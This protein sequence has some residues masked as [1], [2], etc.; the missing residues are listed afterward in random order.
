MKTLAAQDRA[1]ARWRTLRISTLVYCLA[2]LLI[3]LATASLAFVGQIASREANDQATANELRL[4]D[5]A[6]RDRMLLLARDQLTVA[7][8]DRSVANI[9]LRFNPGF[10]RYEFVDS[11]WYE[12]SHNRIFLVDPRGSLLAE[13]R[14]HEVDF[15]RRILAPGGALQV[16]ATNAAAHYLANRIAI[17]DGFG[18][19]SVQGAR[20]D[21]VAEFAYAMV[22]GK[23]ALISAMPIVP[24]DGE[25]V[26]PDGPPVV[27]MS[28]KFIDDTLVEELNAQ[29][30]FPDMTFTAGAGGLPEGVVGRALVAANGMPIGL[31]RWTGDTPGQHIWSVVV[32]VILLLGGLIAAAAI[33]VA[34]KIGT[35]STALE[36]SERDNRHRARHDQLTGLANRLQFSACLDGAVAGL[37]RQ[38]FALIACDLDRFKAVNDTYGHAAGDAVIRTVAER[39]SATVGAAGVVGRIGGDE[40]V[41]L[42]HGFADRPRLMVLAQQILAGLRLP[43]TL[44]DG[45]AADIGI[46]LGIARAPGCAATGEGLMAAADRALY[47]AKARGRGLAVFAEDPD[48]NP[49]DH[50]PPRISDAA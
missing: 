46:S 39:L 15:S 9:A 25:V 35:L 3:A 5:N 14:E 33:G 2:A 4:F 34:W 31:F 18:Q 16:I 6:L 32:P 12:F 13:A 48:D 11:L 23:P 7:R 27:L 38:P 49:L 21:E 45:K 26:L 29:L 42:V 17:G 41:I 44:G 36:E 30:S 8:G 24:D 47:A 43:V 20:V 1:T 19:K 22:D 40:F 37:P 50:A 10:V 28:A